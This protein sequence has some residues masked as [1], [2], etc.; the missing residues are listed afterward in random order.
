MGYR[1]RRMRIT[2]ELPSLELGHRS[3]IANATLHDA[4]NRVRHRKDIVLLVITIPLVPASCTYQPPKP[5]WQGGRGFSD[6]AGKYGYYQNLYYLRYI[7][8]HGHVGDG[9][10]LRWSLLLVKS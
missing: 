3:R 2:S 8:W 6:R 7:C 4:C 5:L 10:R 1:F 9:G